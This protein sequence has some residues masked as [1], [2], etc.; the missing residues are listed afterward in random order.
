[1]KSLG[2]LSLVLF[3]VAVC[4][5]EVEEEDHVLVLTAVSILFDFNK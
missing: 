3:V 4:G 2:L 1:M 5:A